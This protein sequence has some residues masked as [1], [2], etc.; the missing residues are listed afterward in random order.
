MLR[1]VRLLLVFLPAATSL[2]RVYA[3][4]HA[5]GQAASAFAD[6]TNADI[7]PLASGVVESVSGLID[8][9]TGVFQ[10]PRDGVY[11]IRGSVQFACLAGGCVL[12][13][14]WLYLSKKEVGGSWVL[15][16]SGGIM[17]GTS[18]AYVYDVM[19]AGD[20]V[21]NLS[22]NYVEELTAGD[23]LKMVGRAKSSG[24]ST[25]LWSVA[26]STYMHVISVD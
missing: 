11:L 16:G 19:G 25:W 14:A 26:G 4:A 18:A 20:N 6:Q 23:Q 12:E 15:T 21:H 1:C 7:A 5:A 13:Q 24:G 22:F 9:T 3:T 2:P 8:P 17:D 10:A